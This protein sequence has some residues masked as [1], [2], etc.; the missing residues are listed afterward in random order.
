MIP[1]AFLGSANGGEI[2]AVDQGPTDAGVDIPVRMR[3]NPF[4]PA[5][6]SFD[7]TF[8]RIYLTLTWSMDCVL[9]ITPILDGT[10]LDEESWTVTLRRPAS[11]KRQSRVFEKMLRRTKRST[12]PYMYALRGT[13]FALLIE[14][15]GP[16][17]EGDLI[18]DQAVLEFEPLEP[19]ARPA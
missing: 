19:T 11:T 9:L 12:I 3:T 8:E 17:G 14:T 5:G 10:L 7:C 13:W 2:Y 16:L 15:M 6:A 4:A 18:V 1:A